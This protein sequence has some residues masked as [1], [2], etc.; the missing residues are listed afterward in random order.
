MNKK[1]YIIVFIV[2]ISAACSG[3]FIHLHEISGDGCDIF[4]NKNAM[5]VVLSNNE[6]SIIM[7]NHDKKDILAIT[8]LSKWKDH[9]IEKGCV[10]FIITKENYYRFLEQISRKPIDRR[11]K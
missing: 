7:R 11:A 8:H 9:F 2:F 6:Y 5:K 1:L 10:V 3:R 4:I